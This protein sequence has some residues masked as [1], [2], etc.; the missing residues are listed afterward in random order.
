MSSWREREREMISIDCSQCICAATDGT[1][2]KARAAFMLRDSKRST[3]EE[4]LEWLVQ[5]PTSRR[6]TFPSTTSLPRCLV[7][8]I[9]SL[10]VWASKTNP[11]KQMKRERD[12]LN[13][14]GHFF[15]DERNQKNQSTGAM[16]YQASLLQI[17]D[18]WGNFISA[19]VQLRGA[20]HKEH[21]SFVLIRSAFTL[22]SVSSMLRCVLG[23]MSL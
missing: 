12:L 21:P 7:D 19:W 10:S 18:S 14:A 13:K 9:C 1:L 6:N 16:W 11:W 8:F 2:H 20:E 5:H 15:S 22:S 17:R 4:F 3:G 23:L